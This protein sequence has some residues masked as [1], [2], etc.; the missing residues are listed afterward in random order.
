MGSLGSLRVV[1]STSSSIPFFLSKP[2]TLKKTY[3]AAFLI[4]IA[5]SLLSICFSLLWDIVL[6]DS[7]CKIPFII[8]RLEGFDY[9]TLYLRYHWCPSQWKSSSE[10]FLPPSSTSWKGIGSVNLMFSVGLYLTATLSS[11]L[12][13]LHFFISSLSTSFNS[14]IS[15]LKEGCIS[16]KRFFGSLWLL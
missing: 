7:C 16:T 3:H 2:E 12:I 11:L 15:I 6:W 13:L 1:W 9:L 8:Y 5:T 14:L 10:N 4:F